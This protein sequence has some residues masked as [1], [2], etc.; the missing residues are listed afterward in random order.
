MILKQA[1]MKIFI[2]QAVKAIEKISDKRIA[3]E[4]HKRI[5]NLEKEVKEL[6]KDSHPPQEYV[7][8]KN[9]GCRI[10]KTKNK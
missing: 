3:S 1:A 5:K 10:D 2:N 4:H 9:C 8:C 6:K 7:C